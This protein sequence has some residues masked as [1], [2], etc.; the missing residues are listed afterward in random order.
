MGLL[1][2]RGENYA[3]GANLP[4]FS[5]RLCGNSGPQFL[6]IFFT[7]KA[8]KWMEFSTLFFLLGMAGMGLETDFRK[9]LKIGFRPFFV[10]LF[11]TLFIALFSLILVYILVPHKP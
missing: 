6:R 11:S 7:P 3:K 4:S 1:D 2:K 9:L 10:G 8:L 5:L